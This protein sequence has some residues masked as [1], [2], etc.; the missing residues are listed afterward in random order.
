MANAPIYTNILPILED[1][2]K[3]RKDASPDISYVASLFH[4]GKSKIAAKIAEESQE[5]IEAYESERHSE[6]CSQDEHRYNIIHEAAD[7][8][9]HIMVLL[10]HKNIALHQVLEELGRRLGLSGL[11]EKRARTRT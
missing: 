5:L 1:I 9:F 7:L 3:Q 4:A 2:L 11:E 10:A 8:W 6:N